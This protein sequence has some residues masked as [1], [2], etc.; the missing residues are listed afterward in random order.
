MFKKVVLLAIAVTL[1]AGH[2][3]K[4]YNFEKIYNIIDNGQQVGYATIW[5]K[6]GYNMV[7]IINTTGSTKRV[8]VKCSNASMSTRVK[9][10]SLVKKSFGL[11]AKNSMDFRLRTRGLF[12]CG[13]GVVEVNFR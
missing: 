1:F 4:N 13:F 10:G 12:A 2:L 7:T 11:V 3:E 6:N 5:Y 8:T 9:P